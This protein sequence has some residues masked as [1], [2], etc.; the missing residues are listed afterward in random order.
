MKVWIGF[1]M[2]M[3]SLSL[4]SNLA[5]GEEGWKADP[6][7]VAKLSAKQTEFNY[8]ESQVPE[9][10]LPDPL[11]ML[12][13]EVVTTAA[14]WPS[15]REETMELFR[16]N[17]YG[18]RPQTDYRVTFET[19]AQKQGLFDSQATGRSLLITITVG[20]EKYSFPMFVFLP[21]RDPQAGTAEGRMPAVIHI[22][23]RQFPTFEAAATVDDEFWPVR[24]LLKRGYVACAVSTVTI[25][26]D[27]AD[28]FDEGI[29]GF[30]HR[31]SGQADKP[32]ADDAWKALSAWGWGA[33]RA[34]D[35]L[36]TLDQVDSKK[37]GVIGHSRGGKTALW[38][39]AEDTRFAIACSNNSGCGGAALSR[40][41]Y[42]ETIARITRS[43][44]HWFCDRLNTYVGRETELPVDQH[45]LFGLIAPRP[46]YATSAA[47]DLWADPR[48]EYLSMVAA[49]P[50]Y[51]L[52]GEKAFQS[53]EMPSLGKP[54]IEGKMGYH[55]REGGHGLTG[56][57]WN[58]FLDFCDMQWSR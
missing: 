31:A 11:R 34:L 22:N 29:R 25:D 37:V 15:R 51:Q 30:F 43:F 14:Q 5:L 27:R 39:A 13:G 57:D 17:M 47:E 18:R 45:Q 32:P 3:T 46:V 56:Y 16:A 1:V 21:A 58:R 52:L 41:M 7:L 19:V 23:N 10:T 55:I 38:A 44:P 42:G 50:V 35:Y 48:G 6:A 8:D 4:R 24:D 12:D 54:R 2:V 20:K 40:R 49:A 33:S 9:Y 53:S 36:L 26:P 28:G